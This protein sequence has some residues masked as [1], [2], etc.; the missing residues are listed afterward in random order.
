MLADGLYP[1]FA[2]VFEHSF[3]AFYL[4]GIMLG[5]RDAKMGGSGLGTS[6]GSL[7]SRRRGPAKRSLC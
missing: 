4:P 3:S 5:A 2:H 6:R 7:S 1:A